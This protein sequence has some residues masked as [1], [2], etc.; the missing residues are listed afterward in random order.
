[1][2]LDAILLVIICCGCVGLFIVIHEDLFSP[3]HTGIPSSIANENVSP[4]I[5]QN[6]T[7]WILIDSIPDH[8]PNDLFTVTGS[9]NLPQ[10]DDL[11]I[12]VLNYVFSPGCGGP[13]T[14]CNDAYFSNTTQITRNSSGNNTFAFTV[15]T[16][17]FYPSKFRV[18]VISARYD[19]MGESA[20]TL[21]Q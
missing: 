6:S 11:S 8:R 1:M 19:V 14:K 7:Y 12:E 2:K 3:A 15:N 5:L 9:T 16:S 10:N 18:R 21:N 20:F 17:G 13:H 4:S